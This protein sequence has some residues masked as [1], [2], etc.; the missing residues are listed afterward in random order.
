MNTERRN[1]LF[2][3]VAV[4]VATLLISTPVLAGTGGTE[5][6]D[7]YD[8]FVGLIQGT[9]GR[10][11]AILA[12]IGAIAL[13]AVSLKVGGIGSLLFVVIAAA[14]GVAFITSMITAV[15]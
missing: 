4:V 6:A 11:L 2:T 7:L 1:T 5:L 10:L 13:T 3:L 8:W 15:V 12:L 9:G 14:F